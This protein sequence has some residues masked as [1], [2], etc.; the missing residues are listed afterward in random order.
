MSNK[1][2]EN[3]IPVAPLKILALSNCRELGERAN[4]L[5]VERRQKSLRKISN[6]LLTLGYGQ[7]N[8]LVD[9]S[10][11][12][13]STGEGKAIINQSIRGTDLFILADTVNYGES[14]KIHGSDTRMS[15]DD[16]FQD[17][18]RVIMACSGQPRRITVIMPFLYEG[19]QNIRVIN[20]S[21]DCALAL[22]ELVNMGVN[23]IITFDAHDSRVQNAIPI[24]E[25]D[26][27][28]TSYQ[29][30]RGLAENATNLKLDSNHLMIISPDE[31]G[32][33]RAVYYANLLGVDMGMF[34]KRRDYSKK[35]PDGTSPIASIEFLGND[36]TGKDVLVVD[37]M[38][39]TGDT[40][41]GVA[42]EL[43]KR[44]A[45][46]VFLSATF[47]LFTEGLERFDK[48]YKKGYF[49]LLF[50]T[51]LN[52]CPTDLVKRPYYRNI[53]LSTYISLII[54]TVNHDTSVHDILDATSRI[55]ELVQKMS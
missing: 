43:K 18:K 26:N 36:L 10:L 55:Q 17:L 31:G 15:P 32:M 53:D 24:H 13:N 52:Y 2:I 48:Y 5:I 38:I 30:I 6:E 54:D 21:L 20:E 42:G 49:D 9:Y 50:T 7:D 33:Y 29:F 45:D 11:V 4:K 41:L 27:F 51:N 19:R 39:A 34:F 35:L 8:Y 25:F 16:H 1:N 28:H 47:G 46:R 44:N 22:Q 3:A 40:I 14:Y 12:R 23:S 37:D